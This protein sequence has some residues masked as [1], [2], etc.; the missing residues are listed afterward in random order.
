MNFLKSYERNAKT[1]FVVDALC[2]LLQMILGLA[3]CRYLFQNG[4][5]RDEFGISGPA[6]FY[7]GNGLWLALGLCALVGLLCFLSLLTHFKETTARGLLPLTLLA[8]AAVL[9]YCIYILFSAATYQT[10]VSG[11]AYS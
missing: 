1:L 4:L 3:V 10:F 11:G 2:L 9:F 5:V 8:N 7:A 6:P